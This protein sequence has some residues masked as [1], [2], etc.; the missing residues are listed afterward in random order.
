MIFCFTP[1]ALFLCVIFLTA[2]VNRPALGR[3]SGQ[4]KSS[5]DY[6]FSSIG[7]PTDDLIP[8]L[9][10]EVSQKHR[11]S[12]RWRWQW[13]ALALSNPE[14]PHSPEKLYLDAPEAFMQ[15]KSADLT[16]RG[17]MNTVNWSV[18]DGISPS[19]VVN[20]TAFFD[21]SRTLRRGSPMI[22]AEV[23]GE[24]LSLHI[25]YIPIQSR[26]VLPSVDSRWLPRKIL[27]NSSALGEVVLPPLLEYEYD[28][29]RSL[30]GAL[31]DNIGAR[32]SSHLGSVDA[33]LMHF[34]GAAPQPKASV[35]VTAILGPPHIALSPVRITPVS[36]RVRTTGMGLIWARQKWIHRMET[37]YQHT[38]TNDPL[39]EPWSWT[40]VL[41]TE[42]SLDLGSR[43]VTL[44]AQYY[45][46]QNPQAADNLITS[47]YRLLDRTAVL[48]ARWSFSDELT[49]KGSVLYET[50]TEGLFAYLGLD[51]RLS[52]AMRW[53]VAWRSF[54]AH[55]PGL[56]KTFAD[57]D[58][59]NLELT[60]SF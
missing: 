23:G 43:S 58:H 26:P 50:K 2:F 33:F 6:Y 47:S 22:E 56:I 39:V 53:G 17:G 7:E 52:D 3:V 46:T 37:V 54:S 59:V 10:L 40:S 1:R 13:R 34:E 48:G 9:S 44:L 55:K 41:G 28:P 30:S 24:K 15:F 32:L 45:Y 8:Y 16:L 38:L 11:I 5:A 60:Y 18:V 35:A 31:R 4:L 27:V 29:H 12:K 25:V 51:Q 21:P 19:N 20:S 14:S 36:Y 49:F 57:N 42:T